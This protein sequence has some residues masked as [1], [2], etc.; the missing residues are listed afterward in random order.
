MEFQLESPVVSGDGVDM[1]KVKRVIFDPRR[2]EVK[3]IIVEKGV[4]FAHDVA[5]PVE[6][7]RVADPGRVELT[8]TRDEVERL[9]EFFDVDY[10]WPHG[11][12]AAPFGWP[13]GA[14]MWPLGYDGAAEFDR[15]TTTSALV[16]QAAG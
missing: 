2:K 14:V 1:G 6:D 4:F 3:S 15:P 16:H 12:W 9:P 5:V 11:N 8:L 13:S 10:A 7:I